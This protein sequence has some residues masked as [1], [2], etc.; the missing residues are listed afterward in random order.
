[1][2]SRASSL[3]AAKAVLHEISLDENGN[4]SR[5]SLL[6]KLKQLGIHSLMVEGGQRVISSFLG[7]MDEKG[8]P[9]VDKLVITVA[10]KFVGSAGIGVMSEGVKVPELIHLQ[11]TTL[12]SDT[13]VACR[14]TPLA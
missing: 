13:V 1:M 9:V 2:R 10:P 4:L 3:R 8:Q 11:S 6:D 14:I 5:P 12:G 7:A